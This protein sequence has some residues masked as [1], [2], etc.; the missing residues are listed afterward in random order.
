LWAQ[1]TAK[2]PLI[3]ATLCEGNRIKNSSVGFDLNESFSFAI[4]G[5]IYENCPIPLSDHGYAT[6]VLTGSPDLLIP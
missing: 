3:F 5:T 2:I 6:A 4:R 1:V